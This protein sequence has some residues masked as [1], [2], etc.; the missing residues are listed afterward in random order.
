MCISLKNQK[1]NFKEV[2]TLMILSIKILK[3]N[4]QICILIFLDIKKYNYLQEKFMKKFR[5]KI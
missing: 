1:C 2:K 5:Y 4:N 3:L